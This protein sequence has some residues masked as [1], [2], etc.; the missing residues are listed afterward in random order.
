MNERQMESHTLVVVTASPFRLWVVFL[1]VTIGMQL[2]PEQQVL[3][4]DKLK[5]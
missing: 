1:R 4:G 3:E 5:K 2:T